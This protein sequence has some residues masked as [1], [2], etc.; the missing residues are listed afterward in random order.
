M[1]STFLTQ[2]NLG[3]NDNQLIQEHAD[4]VKQI[5][6]RIGAGLPSNIQFDD[7]YQAGLI[8]LLQASKSFDATKGASFKTFA[9]IRIRGAI[10]D[11]VRTS[12]WT[13]RSVSKNLRDI[14]A[15]KQ[16]I[17][18]RTGGQASERAIAEQLNISLARYRQIA[19][20]AATSQLL[21]ADESSEETRSLVDAIPSPDEDPNEQLQKE[22]MREFAALA[23][24][25]LPEK[26]RLVLSLYYDEEL[27]LKDIAV[28]LSVSESRVSQIHIQ[29]VNRL[30]DAANHWCN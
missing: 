6:L 4:L 26:E 8:G 13:P 2:E 10:M 20:E 19:R 27:S 23:I 9:G 18:N 30:K 22:A 3:R 7:L 21:S 25:K 16:T 29:A 11:E 17:E 28:V 14:K 1:H 24:S 5:A 15:A 12:D